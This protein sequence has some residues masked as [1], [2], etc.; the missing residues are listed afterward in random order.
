MKNARNSVMKVK[1]FEWFSLGYAY[2]Q[3]KGN[4]D[5]V[6]IATLV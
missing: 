1:G 3:K 6:K 2:G 5:I 4:S